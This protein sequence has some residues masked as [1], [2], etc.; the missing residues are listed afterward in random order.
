MAN[1]HN[2]ANLSRFYH[3]TT[4]DNAQ[5]IFRLIKIQWLE[6]LLGDQSQSG[7][8]TGAYFSMWSPEDVAKNK[9]PISRFFGTSALPPK[10]IC[11]E[12]TV[13]ADWT[14]ESTKKKSQQNTPYVI[15]PIDGARGSDE[16]I[17]Y[18]LT[19]GK[20]YV[21]PKGDSDES[22]EKGMCICIPKMYLSQVYLME[23]SKDKKVLDKAGFNA[24]DSTFL[25]LFKK[26]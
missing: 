3:Y 19:K 7:H 10:I 12:L 18:C 21:P 24:S 9:R 11:I 5:K 2:S 25:G 23:S 17:A 26:Q 13:P 6:F 20:T 15:E 1:D 22:L 14:V 16:G 8:A 4:Q